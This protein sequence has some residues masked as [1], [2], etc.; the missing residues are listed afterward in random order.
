M[1]RVCETA[2]ANKEFLRY[3]FYKYGG[4]YCALFSLVGVAAFHVNDHHGVGGIHGVP[5]TL[6]GL[7]HPLLPVEFFE[8]GA[9]EGV[10]E[11]GL[12]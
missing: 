4:V 11:C 8:C 3:I 12:A 1:I 7:S 6:G 9:E 10:E 2:R 5:D